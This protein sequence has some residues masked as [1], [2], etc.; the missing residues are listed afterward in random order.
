MEPNTRACIAATAGRLIS[1]LD[2]SWV[3]DHSRSKHI[4]IG[5]NIFDG[6]IQ[7][8]DYDRQCHFS[9]SGSSGDYNLYDFGNQAN[10]SLQINGN[11]FQGYDYDKQ[12]HFNGSVNGNSVTLYDYGESKHFS[13][14]V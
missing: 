1:G 9:G 6:C 11:Q 13:Y 7:L 12:C 2:S 14:S 4:S 5:G 8:Y 3:Y 10:V